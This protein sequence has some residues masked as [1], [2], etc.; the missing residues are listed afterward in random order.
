M[1]GECEDLR[2]LAKSGDDREWAVMPETGNK[3]VKKKMTEWKIL[4]F[5]SRFPRFYSREGSIA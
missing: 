5:Y 1:V 2:V 4:T 3:I